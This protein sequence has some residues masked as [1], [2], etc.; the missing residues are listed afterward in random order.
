MPRRK[1]SGGPFH[2]PYR[3]LWSEA[4]R[5]HRKAFV[6]RGPAQEEVAWL[7]RTGHA[8]ARLVRI[9][10]EPELA[11]QEDDHAE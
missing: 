8:D 9:M 7:R 5:E 4:G 11:P 3:V 10:S 1:S 6:W 2:Y